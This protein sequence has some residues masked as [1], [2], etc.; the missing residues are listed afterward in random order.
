MPGRSMFR[1]GPVHF[2]RERLSMMKPKIYVINLSTR[3]DR[4]KEAEKELARI[5]WRAEFFSAE[6]PIDALGFPSIGARGC[7]ESHLSVLKLGLAQGEHLAILEDDL[8]F[9]RSF[10]E[11]WPRVGRICPTT[12]RSSI[13]HQSIDCRVK[14]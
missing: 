10:A 1:A 13:P 5:D 9:S 14:D 11:R 3:P 7:F 4:R 6:R 12:G 8:N 2:P